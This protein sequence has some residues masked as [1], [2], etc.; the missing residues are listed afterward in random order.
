M[1]NVTAGR[2]TASQKSPPPATLNHWQ[3]T[4]SAGSGGVRVSRRAHAARGLAATFTQQADLQ[5]ANLLW[6]TVKRLEIVSCSAIPRDLRSNF[7][8]ES[9]T[10]A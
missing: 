6:L 1:P 4:I 3:E 2:L 7:C 9:E 8:A 10:R 5:A